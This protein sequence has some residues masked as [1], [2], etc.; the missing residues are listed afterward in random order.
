M[1]IT[2]ATYVKN[3]FKL[4]LQW[5]IKDELSKTHMQMDIT[6]RIVKGTPLRAGRVTHLNRTFFLWYL[7]CIISVDFE[8]KRL[9]ALPNCQIDRG[10]IKA[11]QNKLWYTKYVGNA[12]YRFSNIFFSCVLRDQTSV[13]SL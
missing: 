8:K 11:P 9:N 5:N 1:S 4:L 6:Y 7:T 2:S 12:K 10:H 13:E 3:N